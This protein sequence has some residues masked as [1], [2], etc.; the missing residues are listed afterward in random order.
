VLSG[1][2][3]LGRFEFDLKSGELRGTRIAILL[4]EKPFRVLSILVE[5]NGALVSRDEI[6]KKLWPNDTIVDFEHGINTAMKRLRQAL[7][8]SADEPKYIETVPRRGYRLLVAVERI[9]AAT[10][11]SSPSDGID[12]TP[13]RKVDEERS[14]AND[15][16]TSSTSAQTGDT[17][18]IGKKVSHYRVLEVIGAGGMGMVYRAEDLKLGRQVALKFLPEELARDSVALQRFEREAQTASSL[19][20]PN[21]CTIH[22]VEEHNGQPFIVM[23]LLQGETLRDRLATL[24]AERKTLPLKEFLDIAIHIS[25]GLEAAH[26]KGI[27]H[28][29]I[30]PANIFLTNSGQVK[31]LDFGLAKAVSTAHEA[32]SDGL[33]LALGGSAAGPQPAMSAQ[34]DAALTRL[35]VAVGTAGYMSPE[36]VRGDQ[37][38][39]R[40]DIFSCGLVLYEMATGHRAFKAESAQLLHSAILNERQDSPRKLNPALPPALEVTVN[41]AL[42]KE[43]ER[44]YQTAAQLRDALGE[45][46][47][48]VASTPSRRVRRILVGSLTLLLLA[49]LVTGLWWWRRPLVRRAFQR[50]EMT[51]LTTVGNV[52]FVDISSDGRYLAY[53]DGENGA[54][55]LWVHELRS[56]RTIRIL[57]P[58]SRPMGDG[59]RFTPDGTY[60]YYT[61]G[62]IGATI[63]SLYKVPTLGGSP[64]KVVSDVDRYSSVDFTPDGKQIVFTRHNSVQNENYLLTANSDGTAERSLLVLGGAEMMGLPVWSPDGQTIA[65]GI[66]ETGSG[67]INC[68]ATISKDGGRERRVL[69][70][71]DRISRMA[72]LPDQSGLVLALWPAGGESSSL[73]VMSYPKGDLRRITTD[74]SE[75]VGLSLTH[76][77][78]R[79]VAIQ[80]QT[81]SALWVAPATNPTQA[82]LLREPTGRR[83]GLMGVAWTPD[84]NLVYGTGSRSEL[85]LVGRDGLHLRQFTHTNNSA[86]NPFAS[87]TG[88]T[89]LFT[90]ADPKS[91]A[92]NIWAT[93]R[94]GSSMRQITSGDRNKYSPEM[95]PNGKWITFCTRDGPWKMSI[96]DNRLTKL[97]SHGGKY[98]NLADHPTISPDGRLIAFETW[99]ER[100]QRSK[101]AIVDAEGT[102]A[103]RLLPFIDEPQLPFSTNIVG[104]P[105]RWTSGGD[106]ITYVRTENGASNIWSQ[107]I[108]GSTATKLTSFTS[109]FI[110][111]HAWSRDG[112]Y[113]VMARGNFSRDV[114]M[115]TDLH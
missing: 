98:P 68:I 42:E 114:V 79:L 31:I 89:I 74:L 95:S 52:D 19:D 110:W 88:D 4:P 82:S 30:K 69:R 23:Q 71:V 43:R 1:R 72:W 80:K 63:M 22:E 102:S 37:L 29:D 50:Y 92:W 46:R 28:R 32:V 77:A 86:A 36:Q 107:P 17:H 40:T 73:Q 26:A 10:D 60:L 24:A 15:P 2:V 6:Q 58:V 83:D 47:E 93:D 111:R 104:M 54:Q 25:S 7:G 97:D 61:Q 113:L 70:N 91:S 27:I 108:D 34:A 12:V 11:G 112:K 57:G 75:Y 115:L 18:L 66:D 106:A 99:D 9:D 64:D 94:I 41:K 100:D 59:L 65:F 85:W 81:E 20:H 16:S 21:I 44:R 90:R 51:S 87:S 67:R 35:G 5:N 39:M 3:R 62:D 96:S 8:D 53:S 101:L 84:G 56:S 48:A 103:S 49:L 38:D 78:S 105:V 14:Q 13:I 33:Q 55:S 76:D 109:M 45:L